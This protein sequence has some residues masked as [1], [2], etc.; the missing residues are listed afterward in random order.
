[1]PRNKPRCMI[2]LKIQEKMMHATG[3]LF[4]LSIFGEP[5]VRCK[6][7]YFNEEN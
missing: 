7:S 5:G 1:M 6:Q 4:L 3:N 2:N